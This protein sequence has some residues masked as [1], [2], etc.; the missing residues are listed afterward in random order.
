MEL[1][2]NSFFVLLFQQRFI[3]S[4]LNHTLFP[5]KLLFFLEVKLIPIKSSTPHSEQCK[6]TFCLSSDTLQKCLFVPYVQSR[7]SFILPLFYSLELQIFTAWKYRFLQPGITDDQCCLLS[8]RMEHFLP[9]VP[10]T[11]RRK[12]C[13]YGIS[14]AVAAE[15]EKQHHK[16]QSSPKWKYFNLNILTSIFWPQYFNLKILTSL[17]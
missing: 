6:Y 9:W 14:S 5:P 15:S 11:H 10:G 4:L 2:K 1:C 3:F 8:K 17:F 13:N 16:S 12:F 7:N